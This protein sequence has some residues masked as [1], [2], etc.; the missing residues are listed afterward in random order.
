MAAKRMKLPKELRKPKLA[1]VV[2]EV[3]SKSG[4][5]M[6]AKEKFRLRQA[7][8]Q[9]ARAAIKDMPK[10]VLICK[11]CQVEFQHSQISDVGMASFYLPLKPE[12]PPKGTMCVCP[13]CGHECIYLR[14]DL[15]YRA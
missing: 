2:L 5:P 13:N 1:S 9:F 12:L 6:S 14:T 15:L 10:W 8:R 4:A 11:K 3:S 7:M